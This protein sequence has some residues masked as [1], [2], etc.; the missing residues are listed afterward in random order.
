[1][2]HHRKVGGIRPSTQKS[3]HEVRSS[4]D[5][6][7]KLRIM[8][9]SMKK[10]QFEQSHHP[11]KI[12]NGGDLARCRLHQG[13]NSDRFFDGLEMGNGSALLCDGDQALSG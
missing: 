2:D 5:E 13:W 10:V 4:C 1:M 9:E 6:W 12:E 11:Q 8:R 3:N 7:F